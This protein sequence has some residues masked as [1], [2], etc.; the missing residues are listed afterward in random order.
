MLVSLNQT[1]RRILQLTEI[2]L[3]HCEKHN[4]TIWPEYGTLLG[5][6]RHNSV[7]PWDYDGDFGMWMSDREKLF[8]TFTSENQNKI[9]KFKIKL[10]PDYYHDKGCCALVIEDENFDGLDIVFYEKQGNEIVSCQSKQILER[11]PD[12]NDYVYPE[13][14]LLPLHPEV[15]LGHRLFIPNDPRTILTLTYD[16]WETYPSDMKDYIIPKYLNSPVKSIPEYSDNNSNHND[17]FQEFANL[18]LSSKAPFILKNTPLL[19]ITED[20]FKDL[21]LQESEVMGY[22]PGNSGDK[23][24]YSGQ[25]IWNQYQSGKLMINIV[26]APTMIRDWLGRDWLNVID[27]RLGPN[28]KFGLTWILTIAPKVTHFHTDPPYAGGFMKLLNGSKIWWCVVSEDLKYL[29]DRGHTLDEIEEMSLIDILFLEDD[30]LWGK[31]YVGEIRS[32]DLIWF[33]QDCLHKVITIES[34]LGLGGYI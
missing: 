17:P 5:Y 24:E 33:P 15:F 20:R 10:D 18:S 9:S 30:Y 32:G 3:A 34:S 4:M 7:I 12:K 13:S 2:L 23:Q 29:S 14:R 16:D 26:D 19:N 25:E 6:L 27:E 8:Q 28:D 1:G 11:Y 22:V 21:L 31:I